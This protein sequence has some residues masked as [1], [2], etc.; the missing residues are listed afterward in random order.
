MIALLCLGATACG[1][2]GKTTSS[3]SRIPPKPTG[4]HSTSVSSES[5]ASTTTDESDSNG[6]YDGD[7]G[8][9]LDYG[10]TANAADWQAI[11]ALV[12]DYLAAAAAENG[13]KAC[14]LLNSFVAESVAEDYGQ[15][16]S[17]HGK[18]CAVVMSKLFKRNHREL[19][20][21]SA[22]L[23]VI[24]VKVEGDKALEVMQFATT[25]AARKIPVR[26]EGSTWKILELLDSSLP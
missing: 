19:A 15:T 8:P 7:D 26:R 9:V 25:P 21:D 3:A 6:L 23:K 14:L 5:T 16:P 18:T 20:A 11:T 13:A 24:T 10:H 17:L 4:A 1:G 22:T 2:S 12:K